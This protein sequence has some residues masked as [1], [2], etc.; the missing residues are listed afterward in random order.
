MPG[1]VLGQFLMKLGTFYARGLH[2]VQMLDTV[3]RN[4]ITWRTRTHSGWAASGVG[5]LLIVPW[6]TSRKHK[7]QRQAIAQALT[8]ASKLK[9]IKAQRER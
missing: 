4:A 8:T 6:I 2:E 9:P 3:Q 7:K 1:D 5:F